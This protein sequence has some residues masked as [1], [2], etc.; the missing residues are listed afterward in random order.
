MVERIANL[1]RHLRRHRV[2]PLWAV[3]G[4][5]RDVVRNVEADGFV[6]HFISLQTPLLWERVA[7]TCKLVC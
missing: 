2:Q 1:V 7:Q 4:D 6:G 5:G 3:E